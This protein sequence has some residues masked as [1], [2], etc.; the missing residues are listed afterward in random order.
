MAT[1]L[2]HSALSDNA[3]DF[4]IVKLHPATDFSDT[5]RID[6]EERP[7]ASAPPYEA[8]SYAW[9][10]N[11]TGGFVLVSNRK[12]A[13]SETVET[14]LRH[15]RLASAPR[16]LWIDQL[17]INQADDREKTHQVGQM[18]HV[19]AEAERAVVWLGPAV[20]ETEYLFSAIR[21]TAALI[22]REDLETLHKMYRP[23][24]DDDAGRARIERISEA[25][26]EFSARYYWS[27]LWIFQEF[28]VARHVAI[29]CGE[30][31]IDASEFFNFFPVTFPSE[32][33][34]VMSSREG[35]ISAE[36][37]E[38]LRLRHDAAAAFS[39]ASVELRG[40]I[41]IVFYTPT[42][43]YVM[44]LVLQ[45]SIWW[46]PDAPLDGP[47]DGDVLASRKRPLFEVMRMAQ[48]PYS[49]LNFRGATDE[50]DRIFAMLNL[51]AD[52]D[53]FPEFPD[54]SMTAA[55]AYTVTAQRLLELGYHS[56]LAFNQF[57][58]R[59][60][61]L[62][63]WV[64]DWSGSITEPMSFPISDYCADL[65]DDNIWC[66]SLP[67]DGVLKIDGFSIDIIQEVGSVWHSNWSADEIDHAAVAAFLDWLEAVYNR[68][69]QGDPAQATLRASWLTLAFVRWSRCDG[70]D[71]M[72]VEWADHIRNAAAEE[73]E[74]D[75]TATSDETANGP[76]GNWL[77]Y[78]M[79]IKTSRR[80]FLTAK[81][82]IGFSVPQVQAGDELCGFS[83]TNIPHVLRGVGN[84]EYVFVGDAY[85][86]EG[87]EGE[88]FEEAGEEAKRSFLLI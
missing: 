74:G 1:P 62:P 75:M 70:D 67:K 72:L 41:F 30:H 51:A 40:S 29:V 57:P 11:D 73:Q 69:Q 45:R 31:S 66:V 9:G 6:V 34:P 43:D 76:C 26:E 81:G 44:T 84:G 21:E 28:I 60:A 83:G 32:K 4:R 15:L 61:T 14:A 36:D 7:R 55:Q 39:E 54:Y 46:N 5:P 86:E 78:D 80:P 64:P 35:D 3:L 65:V 38:Q 18:H 52:R 59:M 56:L 71:E 16:L 10:T 27:R 47:V 53:R 63:S 25:F 87:M 42:S 22:A 24:Y 77:C 58:K 79:R 17:C 82:H 33:V 85:V 37:A 12:V 13:V 88:L 2:V 49:D 19:Y 48:V 50:R 20:D 8:L 23:S 68:P